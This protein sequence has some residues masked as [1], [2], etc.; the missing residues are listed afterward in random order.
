[1]RHLTAQNTLLCVV[2]AI[3][4]IAL[5]SPSI[6][7]SA[8]ALCVVVIVMH[9]LFKAFTADHV[10]QAMAIPP[11]VKIQEEARATRE[12]ARDML[13]ESFTE[14]A[15][16]ASARELA[17]ATAAKLIEEATQA[18]L[19]KSFAGFVQSI[20]TAQA[21][22]IATAQRAFDVTKTQAMQPQPQTLELVWPTLPV[23]SPDIPPEEDLLSIHFPFD[24]DV[25]VKEEPLA[26]CEEEAEEEAVFG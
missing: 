8:A 7:A 25:E 14:V 1:M 23:T 19:G 16:M 21:D 18:E 10:S 12:R 26:F 4:L 24:S 9:R 6:A 13:A 3:A 2:G 11:D 17:K 20:P 22:R 15:A 5:K